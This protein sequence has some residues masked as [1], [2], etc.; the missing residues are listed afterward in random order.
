MDLLFVRGLV[1]AEDGE[2]A[3]LEVGVAG[4]RIVALGHELPRDGAAVVDCGGLWL[5]PGLIDVHTHLDLSANGA[6][7]RDGFTAGSVAALAG[8][9]TTVLDFA[10]PEPGQGL[11]EA[12][13]HRREAMAAAMAVDFGLHTVV[14]GQGPD[15]L[16]GAFADLLRLGVGSVKVFTTYPGLAS[17]DR[18]LL[19]IL[20]AAAATG[21]LVEVH[22]ETDALV[23]DATGALAAAGR[24]SLAWH[25]HA[26]PPAA[27]VEAVGRLLAFAAVTGAELYF[28]HLSTGAAARLVGD[29]RRRGRAVTGETCPH[30]LFL[31]AGRYQGPEPERYLMTPPLRPPAVQQALRREL[32]R[33]SLSVAASDHCGYSLDQRRGLP[34]GQAPPGIPGV[35]MLFPLLYTELVARGGWPL[36]RLLALLAGNPARVF[37]LPGKGRVAVGADADLVLFDPGARWTAGDAG[38]GGVPG[39]TPYAGWEM[40]GRVAAVWLRGR[41]VYGPG[42]EAVPGQGRWVP[43]R[44]RKGVGGCGTW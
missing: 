43:Q 42:A 12:T 15:D 11:V 5:L 3:P 32:E 24:T 33:G 8:G 9:V 25:A 26:R 10:A 7:T 39:Y 14:P 4:G 31:D 23:Q 22:A 21:M 40:R 36:G 6:R 35:G 20:R 38:S 17:D 16:S 19:A 34:L 30:Y 18:R 29:A 1:A 13:R 44:R 27:E 41:P 37:G 2:P 28:V